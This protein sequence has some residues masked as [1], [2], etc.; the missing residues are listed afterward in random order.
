[1]G[2]CAGH[3]VAGYM[4]GSKLLRSIEPE[5]G[6]F[7]VKV[8]KDDPL[9]NGMPE[10]F[11]VRQMHNDSITLP[12]KFELLASSKTCLNQ[13]MKHKNKPIYTCQFHPEYYNHDLIRNF[14]AITI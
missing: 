14:I 8:I 4:Y 7:E 13:L 11:K 1:M 12:A 2:I 5:S 9:F 10:S 3:H 6:D